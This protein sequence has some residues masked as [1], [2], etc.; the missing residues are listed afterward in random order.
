MDFI[1]LKFYRNFLHVHLYGPITNTFTRWT[2]SSL[3]TSTGRTLH[4]VPLWQSK[5]ELFAL[6]TTNFSFEWIAIIHRKAR[7]SRCVVERLDTLPK[8]C[9]LNIRYQSSSKGKTTTVVPRWNTT[10]G[11]SAYVPSY[12]IAPGSYSVP[13][14]PSAALSS[15]L[16]YLHPT[17]SAPAPIRPQVP[18]S[19]PLPP[20]SARP[21]LLPNPPRAS[22]SLPRHPELPRGPYCPPSL[23][24]HAPSA[25]NLPAR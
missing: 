13:S 2:R 14:P 16:N 25:P 24:A 20:S 18:H 3:E 5:G 1:P 8:K 6:V 12:N 23:H 9:T 21:P 22:P 11:S 19:P 10:K 4:S 7:F 15:L 17:R